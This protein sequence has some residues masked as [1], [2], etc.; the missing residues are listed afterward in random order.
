M[1]TYYLETGCMMVKHWRRSLAL[2]LALTLAAGCLGAWAVPASASETEETTQTTAET[3]VETEATEAAEGP[4]AVDEARFP[5]PVFRAYVL[6]TVDTDGDGLLSPEEAAVTGVNVAGLGIAS[7]E[8]IASFPALT[9]LECQNNALSELDLSGNPAL[10][11]LRCYRNSLTR[12]D[13]TGCP[14]LARLY[15]GNNQ[16]EGLDLSGS[17][18]LTL[19]QCQ[20][21]RLTALDLSACPKLDFLVCA[22]N[23][24]AFLDLAANPLLTE[25]QAAGNTAP[26]G[27]LPLDLGTIPGF[28]PARASHWENAHV[29]NSLVTPEPR[30]EEIAVTYDL[31][32]KGR[33]ETFTWHLP[34]PQGIPI[35]R[36]SFPDDRLRLL[37]S[38][39]LDTT[40]DG[41]LTPEEAAG[42]AVLDVENYDIASL[43]G[44]ALLT[45]LGELHCGGNRLAFVDVSE[46]PQLAV[47]S[48]DGNEADLVG[49]W[50]RTLDLATVPGFD[51]ARASGWDGAQEEAG[52]LNISDGVDTVR[53]TYDA[54]G[55][56][57]DKTVLLTWH[58]TF[59]Q[60]PE[61]VAVDAETFPDP[62]LRTWVLVNLDRDGNGVLS[63][64]EIDDVTELDLSGAGIASL[65][66][67]E[68]L[69]GLET[70]NCSDNQLTRLDPGLWPGLK[71]LDCSFNALSALDLSHSSLLEELD[72]GGNRLV[73]LD[74][75]DCPEL[76]ALSCRGNGLTALDLTRNDRLAALSC[77]EN[78]LEAL[79]LR[80]CPRLADVN[81]DYNRLTDLA[82]PES[83]SLWS[84]SCSFNRLTRLDVGGQ[85]DL[86]WLLLGGNRVEQLDLSRHY[87][88]EKLDCADNA[89][90]ELDL[91]ACPVLDHLVC[92]GN[93][94]ARLVVNELADP[95]LDRE[96]PVTQA[97]AKE[98]QEEPPAETQQTQPPAEEACEHTFGPWISRVRPTCTQTGLVGHKDCTRCG[99]HFDKNRRELTD[100]TIPTEPDRHMNTEKIPRTEPTCTEDGFTA[101]T[102]CHD[103]GAYISGHTPIPAR[104]TLT[105]WIREVKPTAARPGT[106]A[107]MDCKVCGKHFDA[108]G[109]ELTDLT[110]PFET[111]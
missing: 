65:A 49:S 61:G 18:A 34:Q 29:E 19:L 71:V 16:L 56:A 89:L 37:V 68:C 13:V 38:H 31:D 67:A 54:D 32:G 111:E 87:D 4:L 44:I 98:P 3:T 106:L 79:D 21:N 84:L 103:C 22:D 35:D 91:S 10:E 51:P 55:P 52:I 101:G 20:E 43:E 11:E 58:L 94:L 73:S 25:V 59:P 93:N 104:H 41:I 92:G 105:A 107:H 27:E 53:F 90:T 6:E 60:R 96:T 88:L 70:L 23:C 69:T 86:R 76:K 17:P 81:C 97:P 57:G 40:P 12:L 9:V 28:D 7:L 64:R 85:Q 50:D 1:N 26:A 72:C 2:L 15:C 78:R 24:L 100:L 30:A 77:G 80:K 66:G 108:D 33:T 14:A 42:A 95:R 110:I 5:D 45:G 83:G 46:N 48:A 63:P 36:H 62:V 39:R 8:G 82:L 102:Y 99:R 74:L 47:L 75:S 109:S